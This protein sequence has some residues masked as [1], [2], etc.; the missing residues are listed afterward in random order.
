MSVSYLQYAGSAE[1]LR[2]RIGD[3]TP[4]LILMLGSG[5]DKIGETAE[6]LLEIPFREVPGFSVPT[7]PGHKGSLIFGRLFGRNAVLMQGR[8]HHYEGYS[9]EEVTYAIRVLSLLGAKYLITTNAAGC[10]RRDWTPGHIMLI[11]DHIKLGSES[12]LR[13]PNLPEFGLRFPD[14]TQYYTPALLARARQAADGL[15]LSVYEGVYFYF[16]GPQYE[17]PAEI[18]A[19]R[20]LGGDAVGMSTVPEVIVAGHCGMKILGLTLLTNMASGILERPLDA[21]EVLEVAGAGGSAMT[22]LLEA[23][24][25]DPLF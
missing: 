12:P 25:R 1:Y 20:T 9:F 2:G 10:V 8:L 21:Q 11:T 16:H 13:G 3:F 18:R 6:Q 24:L 17:T 22:A 23:C 19:I 4:E 5:L 14:A 15:K 7:A